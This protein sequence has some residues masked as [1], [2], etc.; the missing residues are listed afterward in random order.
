[1]ALTAN[2][3]VASTA[4]AALPDVQAR[5]D[6]LLALSIAPPPSLPS[7]IAGVQ[8]TLAALQTLIS[9][10]MVDVAA[11]AAALADLQ[12]SLGQ[13]TASLA[14]S[15][16]FGG[17]LGTAGIYY[18]LF[19][20]QAGALSGELGAQLSAGLPGGGGPTEEIAGAVLLARDAASIAA[21]QTV[22]RS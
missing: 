6:G 14:F 16:S 18:Y 9:V 2:A 17:L 8:A 4:N 7:L 22:L 11:T 19:A 1:M 20:G 15:T 13:L 5:V 10:P 21:L 3:T 12:A